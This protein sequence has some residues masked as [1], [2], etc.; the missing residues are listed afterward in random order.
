MAI[1]KKDVFVVVR[2]NIRV[3][4]KEYSHRDDAINE[5]D[6]WQKLVTDWPDGTKISI[7][8]KDSKLHRIY[9]L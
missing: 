7:V 6:Y 8:K 9:N 3:S 4:E 5:Y 1:K 2:D